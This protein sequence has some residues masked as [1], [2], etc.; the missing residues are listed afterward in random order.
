MKRRG[1]WQAHLKA[2]E[3]KLE[4]NIKRDQFMAE[5]LVTAEAERNEFER[6]TAVIDST[7]RR[8]MAFQAGFRSWNALLAC[9]HHV[10]R[11]L[12]QYVDEDYF[13]ALWKRLRVT[14]DR[15]GEV[16]LYGPHNGGVP[17]KIIRSIRTWHKVPKF[18]AAGLAKHK[19]KIVD[20]CD[21]LTELLD[22]VTPGH[23]GD[24]FAALNMSEEGAEALFDRFASP[25]RRK[26]M[27]GDSPYSV[28]RS[29]SALLRISGVTP[30]SAVKSIKESALAKVQDVLPTKVAATTAFRTYIIQGVCCAIA[31]DHNHNAL[32][33]S[34]QL[35][36]DVVSLLAYM[37]CSADDVRKTMKERRQ[38][39]RE[40][41]GVKGPEDSSP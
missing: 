31:A 34:D 41:R 32:P 3:E 11:T 8:R 16:A 7:A 20:A 21:K 23:F 22:A 13:Q 18:T 15:L 24:K 10:Q 1:K 38:R 36:A 27:W 17:S 25:R 2:L 28:T 39:E 29:A 9:Q 14:D 26:H 4:E 12:R 30:A 35:I 37:D 40:G 33:V 5:W 6:W 19:Q